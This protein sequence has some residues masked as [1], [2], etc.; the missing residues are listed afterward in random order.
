MKAKKRMCVCNIFGNRGKY[1]FHTVIEIN[2]SVDLVDFANAENEII[3]V[4][5]E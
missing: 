3:I 4:C 5:D 2:R 1:F